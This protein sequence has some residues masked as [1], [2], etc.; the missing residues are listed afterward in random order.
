MID[1]AK[2]KARV[3]PDVEQ[4]YDEKDTMLYAMGSWP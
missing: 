2:L 4:T 1:Y 3:F